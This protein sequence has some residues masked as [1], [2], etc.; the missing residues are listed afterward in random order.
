MSRSTFIRTSSILI[1][2]NFR[3]W[4]TSAKPG[5]RGLDGHP[6]GLGHLGGLRVEREPE[7]AQQVDVA[8]AMASLTA[9]AAKRWLTVPYCG[10]SAI[11]IRSGVPSA[12]LAGCRLTTL[13][14]HRLDVGPG[15]G[16]D[17]LELD[18][19]PLEAVLD[20]GLGEVL[21]DGLPRTAAQSGCCCRRLAPV[22]DAVASGPPAKASDRCGLRLST[23]KGPATR[24]A[25]LSSYGRS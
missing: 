20:A 23:V 6:V 8:R 5:A 11:P 21:E 10:P 3:S 13:G 18:P 9:L 22:S 7:H 4:A 1:R 12:R 25:C 16:L 24:T 14:R 15:V 2:P 19:L 17:R